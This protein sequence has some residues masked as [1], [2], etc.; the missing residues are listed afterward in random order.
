MTFNVDRPKKNDRFRCIAAT[1]I[2]VK[3]GAGL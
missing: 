3:D 1:Q 2:D